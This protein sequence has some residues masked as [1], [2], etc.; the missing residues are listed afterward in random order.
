MTK[1]YIIIIMHILTMIHTNKS[2]SHQIFFVGWA[3]KENQKSSRGGIVRITE[4]VKALLE[5]M[6]LAGNIESRKKLSAQEMQQELLNHAEQEEIEESEVPKV[7]TIQNWIHTFSRSFKRSVS[8]KT[9]QT[10]LQ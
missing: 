8:Q 2:S 1:R 4:T 3:L 5:K 7:S 6:F 9:L 10:S